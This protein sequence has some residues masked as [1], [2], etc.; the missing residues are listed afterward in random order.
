MDPT[1][2]TQNDPSEDSPSNV[3]FP[4]FFCKKC[5]YIPNIKLILKDPTD[6]QMQLSCKGCDDNSTYSISSYIVEI[7]QIRIPLLTYRKCQLHPSHSEVP[8]KKYCLNCAKHLCEEC[9]EYHDAFLPHHLYYNRST[10]ENCRKHPN[11]NIISYCGSCNQ[12]ICAKCKEKHKGDHHELK[13][14]NDESIINSIKQIEDNYNKIVKQ[15]LQN[16][17]ILIIIL[18]YLL[19][20][21]KLLR[22]AFFIYNNIQ[23]FIPLFTTSEH[24]IPFQETV[25]I[26]LLGSS[27]PGKTSFIKKYINGTYNEYIPNTMGFENTEFTFAYSKKVKMNCKVW[28][29]TGQTFFIEYYFK[30]LKKADVVILFVDLAEKDSVTHCNKY[31]DVIKGHQMYKNENCQVFVIGNKKDLAKEDEV[32]KMLAKFVKEKNL[33]Y[34]EISVKMNSK[35]EVQQ[36]FE[37]MLSLFVEEKEV[38]SWQILKYK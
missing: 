23:E 30:Y 11:N 17:N 7:T 13:S 9:I 35:E 37:N 32:G 6:F 16:E 27:H 36:C 14:L 1:Q 10:F 26:F 18:G 12:F 8:S 38:L 4:H 2:P 15:H 5:R 34:N 25:N 33:F 21:F 24:A 22:N 28:D 19:E 29:V 3:S 31:Y 20:D